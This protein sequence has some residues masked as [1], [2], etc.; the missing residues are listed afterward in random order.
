MFVVAV[1][2]NDRAPLQVQPLTNAVGA[3]EGREEYLDIHALA[4]AGGLRSGASARA[5][6]HNDQSE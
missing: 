6:G 1:R 3:I 4:R 2:F 5:A